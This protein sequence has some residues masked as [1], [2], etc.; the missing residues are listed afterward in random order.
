MR[1]SVVEIDMAGGKLAEVCGQR[2]AFDERAGRGVDERE[3]RLHM[4]EVELGA[5]EIRMG[6]D[7]AIGG[8]QQ[9]AVVAD[10]EIVRADA[11]GGIF[12][13]AAIAVAGIVEADHAAVGAEIVLAG[14]EQ[15]SIRR[16]AAM[17]EEVPLL[18]SGDRHRLRLAAAVDHQREG[19]GA[20]GE[21]D[22]MIG[23]GRKG[24]AVAAG[25]QGRAVDDR[26]VFGKHRDAEAAVA[27]PGS[28]RQRRRRCG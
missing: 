18:G 16:E 22:E 10:G 11:V 17:A 23:C 26:A 8:D 3:R 4:V 12:A 6:L 20:P 2:V 1:P 24:H 5:A 7:A 28:R 19:A 27:D 21:G 15:F 14:I 25:G 9:A 13:D